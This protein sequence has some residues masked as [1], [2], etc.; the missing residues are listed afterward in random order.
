MNA[1]FFSF[2]PHEKINI[3][4][5]VYAKRTGSKQISLFF[6]PGASEYFT[7][8]SEEECDK[9][10]S[11]LATTMKAAFDAFVFEEDIAVPEHITTYGYT[12]DV[13]AG[14]YYLYF[15]PSHRSFPWRVYFPTE[16]EAIAAFKSTTNYL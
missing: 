13:E 1:V 7:Y 9:A 5:C 6:L 16:E 10:W 14:E 11:L 15:F 4:N 12:Y 2:A 8:E 3:S